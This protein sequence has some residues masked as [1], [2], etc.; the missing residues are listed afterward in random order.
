[1]LEHLIVGEVARTRPGEDGTYN[2]GELSPYARC[3]LNVLSRVFRLPV[4]D[5]KPETIYVHADG[6]H[7]GGK[8]NIN[9]SRITLLPF[10]L[11]LDF[12]L[13]KLLRNVA[14][15]HTRRQLVDHSDAP[16]R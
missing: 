6:K 13:R 15:A 12:Q 11:E 4:R 5:H 14:A 16:L 3:R 2:A 8:D 10:L 1:M 7:V 9:R